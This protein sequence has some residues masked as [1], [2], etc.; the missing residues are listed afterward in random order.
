M[1]GH[2]KR[3][4]VGKESIMNREDWTLLAVASAEGQPLSPVQLQKSLFII[5]TELTDCVNQETFYNFVPYNYGPFDPAVYED[6]E[7]L[8]HNEFVDIRTAPGQ[9]WNEYSATPAGIDRA[10]ELRKELL[11]EDLEYLDTVVEWTRNLSFDQLVRAIYK[12][13]S[14]FRAHSVFKG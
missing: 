7:G 14:E 3:H 5:G 1:L 13:Y 10:S 2:L 4:L 6:A 8:K 9:R 11:G 12:E